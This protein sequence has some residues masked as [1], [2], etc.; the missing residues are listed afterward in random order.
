M[1]RLLVGSMACCFYAIQ[2]RDSMQEEEEEAPRIQLDECGV[3][4]MDLDML[5]KLINLSDLPQPRASDDLVYV[6]MQ[7]PAPKVYH[8]R[9]NFIHLCS[10][11]IDTF[12]G[13]PHGCRSL[14]RVKMMIC[15]ALVECGLQL[16]IPCLDPGCESLMLGL[17]K[18]PAKIFLAALPGRITTA[19]EDGR[20]TAR[21]CL[22]ATSRENRRDGFVWDTVF[23]PPLRTLC[24]E[25]NATVQ[26][27][28]FRM[29]AK[30]FRRQN[31]RMRHVY[32]KAF[33]RLICFGEGRAAAAVLIEV[34]ETDLF[35][36]SKIIAAELL[37]RAVGPNED[38]EAL[39]AI[40]L[41]LNDSSVLCKLASL[42]SL[43]SLSPRPF[44]DEVTEA[45]K[46]H[47]RH[48]D[49]G[50]R[51]AALLVLEHI[52]GMEFFPEKLGRC[53]RDPVSNVV[54][55]AVQLLAV[56]L[57]RG[58]GTEQALAALPPLLTHGDW[59][60]R[61]AAVSALGQVQDPEAS[62]EA[63]EL[64]RARPV[65]GPVRPAMRTVTL[66]QDKVPE[67]EK[68]SNCIWSIAFKP[69]GT[70]IIVA[71]G[72]RVLVYD[73]T[74]GDLVHSLKGHKEPCVATA[75]LT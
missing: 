71:A 53:L 39:G 59:A 61:Q 31:S 5:F 52:H 14:S 54:Q 47:L 46:K 23:W 15:Q 26:P 9:G 37:P 22:G 34:I 38:P 48:E 8:E 73:A 36:W 40:L 2:E 50:I 35:D 1:W 69:D 70:Q 17:A 66:W 41:L 27:S 11:P 30:G 51:L 60:V 55:S 74:D 32:S 7:G 19:L 65:F 24:K 42:H 16:A 44:P 25:R 62:I 4:D 12:C 58:K 49:E 72:N 57:E 29:F 64:L 6:H 56:L 33:E 43:L 75:P 67:R 10:H 18:I 63:L 68:W 13:I 3:G 20:E 45:A 28:H 21:G